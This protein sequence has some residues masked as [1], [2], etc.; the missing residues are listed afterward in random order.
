[1]KKH[2][3]Q[4]LSERADKSRVGDDVGHPVATGLGAGAGALAG[5]ELGSVGGLVG[6]AAGAV[7]GGIAGALGGEGVA[8]TF[9]G[10]DEDRHWRENYQS[11]AYVREGE[12][13]DRYQPAYR[14][15]ALSREQHAG[16]SY[17]EIEPGLREDW[18]RRRAEHDLE[19]DRASPA[20]RDAFEYQGTRAT[21]TRRTRE[22]ENA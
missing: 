1:M 3:D 9:T 16:R 7:I 18:N 6:M 17:D 22:M 8:D 4:E 21:T 2:Q 15:G 19:W 20:I 12:A 10:N 11:R 5:A 13:Y 14:Y